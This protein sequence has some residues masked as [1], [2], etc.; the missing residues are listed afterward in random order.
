MNYIFLA[1][2]FYV[3]N[4]LVGVA[5]GLIFSLIGVIMLIASNR[6]RKIKPIKAKV[7]DCFIADHAVAHMSIQCFDVVV[8]FMTATGTKKRVITMEQPMDIGAEIDVCYDR[9]N[10]KVQ[11]A[12]KVR[13][14]GKTYPI[15][16]IIAGLLIALLCAA[17]WVMFMFGAS[18][19]P[20]YIFGLFAGS[21]FLFAGSWLAIINPYK[22]KQQMVNCDIVTG[23]Q[24]D[25]IKSDYTFK[26][27]NSK[28]V[29]TNYNAVFEYEYGGVKRRYK[30]KVGGSGGIGTKLG[31]KVSIVINHETGEVYCLEDEKGAL[32]PG[33]ILMVFGIAVIAVMF[34]LI[35]LP[36]AMG[37]V[38]IR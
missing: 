17:M 26:Y 30:S 29:A 2:N 15:V 27:Y 4:L 23:V 28:N 12:N 21:V 5:I 10:D 7:T 20:A 8:A 18:F 13:T 24:V 25:A 31:R 11:L 38:G 37:I 3:N 16:F 9:K 14:K 33:I 6:Y 19:S 34:G 22:R 32:A 35:F 1:V 36:N